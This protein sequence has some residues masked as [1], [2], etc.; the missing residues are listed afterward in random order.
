M[1]RPNLWAT[2]AVLLLCSE[3]ACQ[4]AAKG[5][6]TPVMLGS[7]P[8][9]TDYDRVIALSANGERIA[10]QRDVESPKVEILS[11]E[12]REVVNVV[13]VPGGF[14]IM[15]VGAMDGEGQRIALTC[16][17]A[18]DNYHV[19]VYSLLRPE[20][21]ETRLSLQTKVRPY[22]VALDAKGVHLGVV[23]RDDARI[24]RRAETN[25]WQEVWRSP[26]PDASGTVATRRDNSL[27]FSPNGQ[28]AAIAGRPRGV[29]LVHLDKLNDARDE[30]GA[31]GK[32]FRI[33]SASMKPR[34]VGFS[35]DSQHVIC[36]YA[37]SNG[38]WGFSRRHA[39]H[40]SIQSLSTKQQSA[41]L[42]GVTGILRGTFASPYSNHLVIC[43]PS[44]RD[45]AV[46]PGGVS[47][48]VD[49]CT[50]EIL[51]AIHGAF[52]HAAFKNGGKQLVGVDSRRTIFVWELP[53]ASPLGSPVQFQ[54]IPPKRLPNKIQLRDR[55]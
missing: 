31:K 41:E 17:D 33:G 8:W 47:L 27:A 14:R 30:V 15:F 39:F 54:Q 38:A 23:G 26:I 37:V 29:E 13:R 40:T 55:K 32:S 19:L 22:S 51:C 11:T 46:T 45:G 16:L 10:F 48:V 5:L 18:T 53:P 24:W 3:G 28:L 44:G 52:R 34:S 49:V 4:Q 25:N 35:A 6:P 50:Q 1:N 21:P 43:N 20:R 36:S 12:T 2:I 9:K 42:Y 7:G